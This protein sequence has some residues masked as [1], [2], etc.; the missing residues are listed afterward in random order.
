MN[1]REQV[2]AIWKKRWSYPGAKGSYS[3]RKGKAIRA[4]C[5]DL[6]ISKDKFDFNRFSDEQLLMI[7]NGRKHEGKIARSRNQGC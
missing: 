1:Y 4:T 6:G 7:V 5:H 3:R 2:Q